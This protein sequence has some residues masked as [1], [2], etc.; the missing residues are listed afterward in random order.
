MGLPT[1]PRRERERRRGI[2][3]KPTLR[4]KNA[5]QL[6]LHIRPRREHGRIWKEPHPTAT[7]QNV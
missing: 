4:V 2:A 7:L 1:L 5:R 6:A 3:G